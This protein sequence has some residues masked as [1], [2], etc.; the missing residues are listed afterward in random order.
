MRRRF[1]GRITD[2]NGS[3]VTGLLVYALRVGADVSTGAT[4]SANSTGTVS[5][6]HPG[7][8]KVNDQVKVLTNA[9]EVQWDFKINSITYNSGVWDLVLLELGGENRTINSTQ[10]LVLEQ[11]VTA[12]RVTWYA[13]D[14]VSSG[15]TSNITLDADGELGFYAEQPDVDLAIVNS[16]DGSVTYKRDLITEGRDYVTP[17]EFG[18]VGDGTTDD[19]P[20]FQRCADFASVSTKFKNIFVPAGSYYIDNTVTL[21]A[22]TT[23]QGVGAASTIKTD[24]GSVAAITING[25]NCRVANLKIDG[26]TTGGYGVYVNSSINKWLLEDLVIVQC[27]HGIWANQD[28]WIGEIRGCYTE[29]CTTNGIRLGNN[30]NAVQIVGGGATTCDVG[31][32]LFGSGSFGV[33]LTGW[34]AENCTSYGAKVSAT[35]EEISFH[36]G[37]FEDCG[38]CIGLGPTGGSGSVYVPAASIVGVGFEDSGIH[39]EAIYA[40]NV[41]CAGNRHGGTVSTSVYSTNLTTFPDA[42]SK[43]VWATG[44]DY[45]GVT[46]TVY[47]ARNHVWERAGSEVGGTLTERGNITPGSFQQ[48]FNTSANTQQ[49]YDGAGWRNL[50]T[51]ETSSLYPAFVMDSYID[52]NGNQLRMDGS[53][54]GIFVGTGTP[55]GVVTASMGSLYINKNGGASTSLYVKE[56]GTG[57]TGWVGK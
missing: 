1:Q 18:A 23:I 22:N 51:S 10:R 28:N 19:G 41:V 50:L 20:A 11:N 46:G 57:N 13:N 48:Y 43:Q 4:I 16:A 55:E 31:F 32:N 25:N 52:M 3:T 15:S 45:S 35:T 2:E 5:V 14:T 33:N 44:C 6:Y 30:S 53:G 40:Q 29:N 38:V 39:I 49:V 26:Q 24:S 21:P 12:N 34:R 36:G 8:L 54:Y 7:A 56:T 17:F 47:S 37:Y 42:N 9:G 27:V